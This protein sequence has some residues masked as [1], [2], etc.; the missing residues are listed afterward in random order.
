MFRRAAGHYTTVGIVNV[1]N[2]GSSIC[3]V[4]L[5]TSRKTVGSNVFALSRVR[6]P[7][8]EVRTRVRN[9]LTLRTQAGRVLATRGLDVAQPE[10]GDI[11]SEACSPSSEATC[12]KRP[13]REGWA[14]KRVYYMISKLFISTIAIVSQPKRM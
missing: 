8:F 6:H 5:R 11:E 7:Y 14:S 2:R 4:S 1:V 3:G 13:Q 12:E 9:S 10:S